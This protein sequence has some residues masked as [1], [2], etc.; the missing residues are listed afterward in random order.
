MG[1]LAVDLAGVALESAPPAEAA[2]LPLQSSGAIL[3]ICCKPAF[4]IG[5]SLRKVPQEMWHRA[6]RSTELE[7]LSKVENVSSAKITRTG[8]LAFLL[9]S[10]CLVINETSI[11]FETFGGDSP[12]E[13]LEPLLDAAMPHWRRAEPQE[14]MKYVTLMRSAHGTGIDADELWEQEVLRLKALFG[15]RSTTLG[16]TASVQRLYVS[17]FLNKDEILD[18]FHLRVALGGAWATTQALPDAL[19]GHTADIGVDDAE[20]SPMH[21]SPM[22]PLPVT[23][24][25]LVCRWKALHGRERRSIAAAP[26]I[27]ELTPQFG[28]GEL[29][30]AGVFGRHFTSGHLATSSDLAPLA[31]GT[32][33]PMDRAARQRFVEA[34]LDWRL[35][36]TC[37]I[38]DFA[39]SPMLFKGGAPQVSGFEL[40]HSARLDDATFECACTHHF[41]RRRAEPG[42]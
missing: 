40:V 36:E 11:T 23:K 14:F 32:T 27:D 9:T 19:K 41:Y 33:M 1:S 12:L 25:E 8:A 22:V 38:T 5:S 42:W 21:G 15:G 3:T 2:G 4:V 29:V 17:N 31:V 10:A 34:A 37:S 6:L 20:L 35:A 39:I 30:T 16:S 13:A 7:I 26:A 24:M 28:D 18:H